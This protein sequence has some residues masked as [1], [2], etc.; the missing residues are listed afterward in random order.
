M[1]KCSDRQGI[2]W[3]AFQEKR[4]TLGERV[5]HVN[6]DPDMRERKFTGRNQ[7]CGRAIQ[8]L[9]FVM[10]NSAIRI[11]VVMMVMRRVSGD[12]R[13]GEDELAFT[14]AAC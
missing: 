2:L 1:A 12:G 10:L 6:R 5:R 9:R 8:V 14:C 3:R 13:V 4:I 7:T 11:A